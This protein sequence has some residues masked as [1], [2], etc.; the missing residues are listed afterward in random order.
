MMITL[1]PHTLCG[2]GSASGLQLCCVLQTLGDSG[3]C[4]GDGGPRYT[5]QLALNCSVN[6]RGT[7]KHQYCRCPS[8]Y[9][10]L[11]FSALRGDWQRTITLVCSVWASDRNTA[12]LKQFFRFIQTFLHRL[13][14]ICESESETCNR[15]R[16][17]FMISCIIE[18]IRELFCSD[19]CHD[20]FIFHYRTC[21]LAGGGLE[22]SLGPK[23]TFLLEQL[24]ILFQDQSKTTMV[25]SLKVLFLSRTEDKVHCTNQEAS[26]SSKQLIHIC[27]VFRGSGF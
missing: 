17:D 8:F 19:L 5:L 4:C 25:S 12:H 16:L 20:E 3:P 1:T 23:T 14:L 21:R 6:R 11:W 24:W 27:G 18:N 15:V 22:T 7:R 13:N 26:R 10:Q 9:L 2:S